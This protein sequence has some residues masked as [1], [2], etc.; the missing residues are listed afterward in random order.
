M[1]NLTASRQACVLEELDNAVPGNLLSL[2]FNDLLLPGSEPGLFGERLG[3]TGV[4]VEVVL[5]LSGEAFLVRGVSQDGVVR[6]GDLGLGGLHEHLVGEARREGDGV[7]LGQR[8][9]R[10]ADGCVEELRQGGRDEDGQ[11]QSEDG[12]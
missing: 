1:E 11:G 9:R 6:Q 4:L 10:Q 8:R 3:E 5:E 2:P 7:H 12:C